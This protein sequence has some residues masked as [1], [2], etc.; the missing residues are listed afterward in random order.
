MSPERGHMG[1][2]WQG[3][4]GGAVQSHIMPPDVPDAK[5][6]AVD[7]CNYGPAG[8]HLA[9]TPFSSGAPIPYF[10]GEGIYPVI[11]YW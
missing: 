8:F 1:H 3:C 7:L 9:L 4:R 2:K 6:K 10:T 11:I 5:H